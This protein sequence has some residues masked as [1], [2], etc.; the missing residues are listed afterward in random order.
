M[1]KMIA[2]L[3]IYTIIFDINNANKNSNKRKRSKGNL[4]FLPSLINEKKKIK[5][6]HSRLSL[7]CKKSKI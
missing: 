4:I 6:T 7:C 2:M 5:K 3:K 1:I